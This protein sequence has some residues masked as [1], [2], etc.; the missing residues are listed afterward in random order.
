M[1]VSDT[2]EALIV[3]ISAGAFGL[4]LGSFLNVVAHRVPRGGVPWTPS[5]SHCPHCD[6]EIRPRDNVPIVSWLLLRGTCRNCGEPVSWRYPFFEALTAV[7]FAAVGAYDGLSPE[8]L[9]DLLFV[10]TLVT[11]TNT[12]ID[13][14]IVPNKVLV[15]SFLAGVVAQVV[16]RPDQWQ[17]WTISAAVAFTAMFLVVLAYPRG[18]GMGDAKLAGVMGLYLGRAVAPALLLAF[19]IGTLVGLIVMARKG[20]AAGRKTAVPFVPFLAAGGIFGLFF[21]ESVVS[22]YLETF[23]G[24]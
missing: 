21:G 23:A 7:L 4:I 16:A 9:P 19:F 20:V 15:V 14:R 6:A 17:N 22:W 10:A 2:Q 8:L 12:D 5:R 3:A 1:N 18:M 11:V 13:L 24:N